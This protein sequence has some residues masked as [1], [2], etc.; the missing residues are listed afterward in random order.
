MS[1]IYLFI[2]ANQTARAHCLVLHPLRKPLTGIQ[3]ILPRG[4]LQTIL[5]RGILQTIFSPVDE[6][7]CH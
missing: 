5:P 3:N 6:E 7:L 1:L 2:L 4:I